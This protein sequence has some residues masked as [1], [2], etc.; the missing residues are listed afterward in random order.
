MQP[1]VTLTFRMVA[2]AACLLAGALGCAAPRAGV[3]PPLPP[4]RAGDPAPVAAAP[5]A[6]VPSA[7]PV[8]LRIE[9]VGP[10]A[11]TASE[12]VLAAAAQVQAAEARA[13]ETFGEVFLPKLDAFGSIWRSDRRLQIETGFGPLTIAS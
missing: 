2:P 9:D 8:V 5:S 12:R 7:T 4:V 3:A 6:T 10:L 1:R 11:R 13:D